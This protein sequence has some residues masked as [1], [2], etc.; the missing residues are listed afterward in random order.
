MKK[1]I[2]LIGYPLKHSIS[3]V[4]QQVALDYYGLDVSYKLQ[5]TK[6]TELG[7]VVTQLR[8]SQYLGANVTV[9]YKETVIPLL[10]DIDV[11][12]EQIGAVN[13]IKK[14]NGRLE[15]INTD[16]RGFLDAL[17]EIAGFSASGKSAIVL[18]AGGAA[19]A[20]CFALIEENLQNLVIV[21][22][23]MERAQLLKD[24][25]LRYC[26]E[27][28]VN[29]SLNAVSFE[30]SEIK[31]Y[32]GDCQLLVNSTTFGMKH[33]EHEHLS[34]ISKALIP[35]DAL[36]YD[37]VYNPA[38]TPLLKIA[39]DAGAKTLGGLPM[40]V[41]QGAAGFELW[42]GNKAPVDIMMKAGVEALA[43]L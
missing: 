13:T 33:S 4:V 18:G 3:P 29:V 7:D 19:R 39:R 38:N 16:A 43:N 10:D 23:N 5:E 24:H 22:R 40:L 35:V 9:P 32:I 21:N 31:K 30:E 27:K 36:V 8:S 2:E 12:A 26:A 17:S 1:Y 28:G 14:T 15:G 6:P 25:L 34:P 42:T 11:L 20:V 41:F 37:L